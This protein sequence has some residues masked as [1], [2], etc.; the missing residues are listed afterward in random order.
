MSSPLTG[1][2]P[3]LRT[4]IRHDGRLLAPWILFATALS[5]SSV[6]VYP[7]IFPSVQ[8]RAGLAA[9]VGSNPALGL[10]FGPA[11]NLATTDGFNSWRSLALGGLLAGLGVIFAITRATRAQEDSGQAELLA[12]AVMG[13]AARLMTG[14]GMALIGSVLIGLVAGLVT[15]AC[16][17]GWTDSM[18]LGATFTATGFMFTGVAAVAAQIGSDART[19]NSIAVGTLGVLFVA[20]GFLYAVEAP[21]WTIW[22]DP[23]GWMTETKP[24]AGNHW[25]PLLPAVA[26]T[27]VLLIIAFILQDHRDFGVG[28]IEPRPGPPRGRTRS[29]WALALRMNR[30]PIIT[31]AIAFL[32]LGFVFGYFTTSIKDILGKDSAVQQVLAAGA[33]TPGEL[34]TAFV[35]TILS[36]VGILA[37]I[38]AIQIMLKVRSEELDDRVEVIIATD[39]TRPR[40]YASNV[41]LAFLSS[42]VYV[43]LAGLLVATLGST[44]NLGI[45]F[46]DIILQ[47]LV[48]VPAV[49]TVIAVAV[50]VVGARPLVTLAAWFGVLVSFVLTVLGPTFKFWD[51]VLAISPFWHVPNIKA[52]DPDWFG[53][54]WVSLVTVGF[55]VIG[56]VGF[57]RRDLAR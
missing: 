40:Y 18:L 20:R 30:A 15:V 47:A 26:L 10:I 55:L 37:A 57:R 1:T 36:L 16:G 53:L 50:A 34:I 39:V 35:L 32:A 5:V 9:A 31:W 38:P 23:L 27:I 2:G 12:S 22:L 33:S 11:Y 13:R 6:L 45:T 43:M 14:I 4:S 48:I 3:L 21:S 19:A 24:A 54:L 44:A 25:W 51:W 29:T 56:F 52:S 28:A 46:G 42:A 41:V 8:A 49:W 7:W 17:G